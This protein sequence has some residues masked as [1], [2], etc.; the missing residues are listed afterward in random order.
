VKLC[1]PAATPTIKGDD[2]RRYKTKRDVKVYYDYK[3]KG[4]LCQSFV[5]VLPRGNR[6]FTKTMGNYS[7]IIRVPSSLV[8]MTQVQVLDLQHLAQSSHQDTLDTPFEIWCRQELCQ[9]I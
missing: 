9:D 8:T 1:Q 2:E 6:V 5:A 7:E 3:S 4:S